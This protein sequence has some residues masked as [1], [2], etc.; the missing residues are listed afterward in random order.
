VAA[1]FGKLHANVMRSIRAL[2]M[3]E[4][5]LSQINFD[6]AEYVDEQGKPRA[7]FDMD[8]D[9]FTLIAMGFTGSKALRFKIDYI[10]A[11]NRMEA[12]LHGPVANDDTIPDRQ[13]MKDWPLEKLRALIAVAETY[14]HT[15]GPLSAQWMLVQL[16][17]PLPPRDLIEIGRQLLLALDGLPPAPGQCGAA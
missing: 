1:C 10:A 9:G 17:F 5:T 7:A 13:D 4:P 14:R 3:A 8:R 12:M 16:G 2:L 11:F 6:L 15:F